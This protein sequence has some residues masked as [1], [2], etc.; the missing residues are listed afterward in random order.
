MMTET[1]YR[2]MEIDSSR[3]CDHDHRTVRAATHC[4]FEWWYPEGFSDRRV[5]AVDSSDGSWRELSDGEWV[6]Y[7]KA[8]NKVM[9]PIWN[10]TA[11]PF[12]G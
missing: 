6:E 10:N 5:V 7:E 11:S 4:C 9:Y 12:N 8:R 3:C 2:A 1:I